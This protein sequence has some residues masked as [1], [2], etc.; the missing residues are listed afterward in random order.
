MFALIIA[1]F[2]AVLWFFKYRKILLK[3]Q[4]AIIEHLERS[5]KPR[6]K[7]YWL[8]GYLVGF[9]AKYWVYRGN[10]QRAYAFYTTPPHHVFFYIPFI[11]LFK[12]RERLEL[13]IESKA[14]R[15]YN[16]DT[17]IVAGDAPY[18]VRKTSEAELR[19]VKSYENHNIE[20]NGK[21]YSIYHSGDSKTLGIGKNLLRKF[22]EKGI[23]LFRLRISGPKGALHASIEPGEPEDVDRLVGLL[24]EAVNSA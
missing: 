20:I 17:V 8:L 13:T 22:E 12:K 19:E 10:I 23:R 18:V 1:S 14:L 3:R 5:L 2:P 7:R 15:L 16:G 6:D 4:I 24:E 9:R 21:R 11:I